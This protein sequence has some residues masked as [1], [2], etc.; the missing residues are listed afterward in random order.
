MGLGVRTKNEK[1]MDASSKTLQTKLTQLELTAGRTQS[2]IGT[3]NVERIE[4]HLEEF[5]V[6]VSAVDN[7]KRIVE[8]IKIAKKTIL[9]WKKIHS[10]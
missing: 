5:K 10:E 8:E 3:R 6:I 4:R 1:K 7:A 2:I 9:N